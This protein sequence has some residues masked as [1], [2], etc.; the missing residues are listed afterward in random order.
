M[1]LTTK[2]PQKEIKRKRKSLKEKKVRKKRKM[3]TRKMRRP[4]RRKK[5]LKMRKKK[6]RNE[7]KVESN[8]K[9][10]SKPKKVLF[11]K[12]NKQHLIDFSI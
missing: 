4:Q 11:L 6:R 1:K 8:L 2:L 5:R 12:I 9:Y 3:V 10:L 7:I